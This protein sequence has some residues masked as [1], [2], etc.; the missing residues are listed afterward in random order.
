M[1]DCDNELL[2]VASVFAPRVRESSLTEVPN[3]GM[4]PAYRPPGASKVGRSV[5]PK[6]LE[7][8]GL[9]IKLSMSSS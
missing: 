9:S 8:S 7:Y 3:P 1:T 6:R 4:P 5:A 2:A